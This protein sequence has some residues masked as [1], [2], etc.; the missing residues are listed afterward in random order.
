MIKGYLDCAATA[1]PLACAVDAVKAAMT[2][3]GNPSSLHFVGKAA[4]RLVEGARHEAALAAGCNDSC[5]VFTSGCTESTA[6][7]LQSAAASG[8]RHGMHI[9]STAVEHS[10]TLNTLE[11]LSRQGFGVTFVQPGSGGVS[12]GD[13]LSAVRPDTILV[14]M[15]AVNNETGEIMPYEDVAAGLKAKSPHAVFYLDAVQG[16]MKLPL[17]LAHVDMA[18]MSG[19]KFGGIKGCGM[20][21][22]SPRAKPRQLVFGGGQE[23]GIRPGTE[24]VPAIAA[25]GAA[26]AWRRTHMEADGAHCAALRQRLL[27]GLDARG[28]GYSLNAANNSAPHIVNFS[29]LRGKSEV[30]VRALS[31]MG[32]CVSGGSACKKGARSHVL[33]AMKLEPRR[34]DSAL[35]VSFCSDNTFQDVD[36]LLDALE[37]AYKLF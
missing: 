32:V 10:A 29:P 35:R 33:S 5:V 21:Y 24:A 20:L 27:G 4:A 14:A 9:V 12:A 23:R 7:A 31:D 19:H 25:F 26:C 15:Q 37:R 3:F 28:I 2:S 34:I 13:V 18:G 1:P 16:F 8:R 22:V 17:E 36:M 30:Y 11:H 6:I